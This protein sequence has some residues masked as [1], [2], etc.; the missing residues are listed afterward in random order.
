MKQTI[1][2]ISYQEA[3]EKYFGTVKEVMSRPLPMKCKECGKEILGVESCFEHLKIDHKVKIRTDKQI[4]A[5]EK[6]RREKQENEKGFSE[7]VSTIM[8]EH[9]A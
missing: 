3:F 8:G 4:A 9:H 7:F 1:P 6:R 5:M 2:P